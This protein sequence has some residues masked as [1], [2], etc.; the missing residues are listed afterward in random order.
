MFLVRLIPSI[1]KAMVFP[2]SIY[3]RFLDES[4]GAIMNPVFD[5][6]V[7]CIRIGFALPV[8]LIRLPHQAPEIGFLRKS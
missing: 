4:N 1:D 8:Q 2:F 5:L 6:R 3:F 7:L